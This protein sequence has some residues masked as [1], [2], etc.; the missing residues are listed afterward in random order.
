VRQSGI[1]GRP[2]RQSDCAAHVASALSARPNCRAP[3]VSP[4]SALCSRASWQTVDVPI[5]PP[6]AAVAGVPARHRFSTLAT[7]ALRRLG[8]RRPLRVFC[9]YNAPTLS[10]PAARTR[11]G[12]GTDPIAQ[13]FCRFHALKHAHLTFPFCFAAVQHQTT[14]ATGATF[15]RRNPPFSRCEHSGALLRPVCASFPLKTALSTIDVSPSRADAPAFSPDHR[16]V[17]CE[18][19]GSA[20]LLPYRRRHLLCHSI[21]RLFKMRVLATGALSLNA[22]T[23]CRRAKQSRRALPC[24]VA[25]RSRPR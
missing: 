9:A 24:R 21:R 7:C 10:R 12:L 15:R 25:T 20:A 2:D 11:S 14:A 18:Q 19:R 8:R 13:G 6:A 16:G 23:S 22:S 4:S 5:R 3:A 1:C 17:R